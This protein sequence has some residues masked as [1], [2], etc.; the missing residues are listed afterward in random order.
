[1]LSALLVAGTWILYGTLFSTLFCT[2]LY[3]YPSWLGIP[4]GI[5]LALLQSTILIEFLLLLRCKMPKLL[6]RILIAWPASIIFSAFTLSLFVGWFLV[7]IW[8]PYG[9]LLFFVPI[10]IA[11]IGL[12][13]TTYVPK[14]ITDWDHLRINAPEN[15]TA[16]TNPKRLKC[17]QKSKFSLSTGCGSDVL[18][19]VQITGK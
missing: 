16:S 15:F 14:S 11:M 18:R 8:V 6:T 4:Y 10:I 19:L 13:Q 3:Q 12:Y 1:M 9:S 2:A 17:I 5:V 7:V